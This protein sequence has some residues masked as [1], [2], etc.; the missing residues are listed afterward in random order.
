MGG[1]QDQADRPPE[2]AGARV[3]LGSK[4][5]HAC[6]STNFEPAHDGGLVCVDCGVRLRGFVEEQTDAGVADGGQL[7]Y[8]VH[9]EFAAEAAAVSSTGAAA[10]EIAV[11]LGLVDVADA[12]GVFDGG[13]LPL[14]S[15]VK[16][17][18]VDLTR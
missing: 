1:T 18:P 15:R 9:R 6:Q 5:C 16:V 14:A 3:S 8:R 4:R 7:R 12:A 10:R 11:A 13:V 2:R 17:E